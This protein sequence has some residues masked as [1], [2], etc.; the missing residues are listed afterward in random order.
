M[1]N[2]SETDRRWLSMAVENSRLASP[3][4]T[5]YAVGVVIVGGNTLLVTGYTGEV[6]ERYHAEEA[7]LAKL[8]KQPVGDLAHAT[9]YST[10]EP[11]STRQSHPKTCT[12]LIT[13]SGIRRVVIALREPHVFTSQP[14]GV[15]TLRSRGLEVVE[16]PGF[17]HLVREVNAHVLGSELRE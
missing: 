14:S 15:E 4:P 9:L 5:N 3:T 7:A 11:C 2:K 13:E 10:L 17:A 6:G 8:A 16:V 1:S 12:D